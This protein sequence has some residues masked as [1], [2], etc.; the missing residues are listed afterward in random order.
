M[1]AEKFTETREML[2]IA[3]ISQHDAQDFHIFIDLPSREPFKQ[4]IQD[5]PAACL[6]PRGTASPIRNPKH[7]TPTSSV[8]D[9]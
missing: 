5:Q 6:S 8:E 3:E 9:G 4:V 7:R 1:E 2:E